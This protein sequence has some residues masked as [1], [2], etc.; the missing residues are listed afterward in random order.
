MQSSRSLERKGG[1]VVPS[2]KRDSSCNLSGKNTRL[3]EKSCL[4]CG[5]EN[6]MYIK[7]HAFVLIHDK[8]L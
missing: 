5:K 7:S 3:L 1:V 4:L 2:T 6:V 8:C